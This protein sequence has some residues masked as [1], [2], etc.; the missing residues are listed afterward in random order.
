[1]RCCCSS[2]WCNF[3]SLVFK[4]TSWI[5]IPSCEMHFQIPNKCFLSN[6]CQ[7]LAPMLFLSCWFA[8]KTTC[9]VSSSSSR[10]VP[11]QKTCQQLWLLVPQF[12]PAHTKPASMVGKPSQPGLQDSATQRTW[13]VPSPGLWRC[14]C[15][16]L[17]PEGWRGE[18]GKLLT[19]S[20][21]IFKVQHTAGKYLGVIC[22]VMLLWLQK[23]YTCESGRRTGSLNFNALLSWS[24]F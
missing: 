16:F 2:I 15:V 8:L 20:L 12:W 4:L 6:M 5:I 11:V 10:P 1:M 3:W 24:G 9:P 19:C 14:S 18:D 13:Q 21:F 17:W 7:T 23:K 22:T